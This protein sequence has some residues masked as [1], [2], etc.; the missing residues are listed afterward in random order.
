M[1]NIEVKVVIGAGYGDEGKGLMTDY[2]CEEALRKHGVSVETE[3]AQRER[4]AVLNVRFNGGAQAGH[5]VSRINNGYEYKHWVFAQYGSGTFTGVDTYLAKHFMVNPEL[6]IKEK[7]ALYKLFRTPS[8][9]LIDKKCSVTLPV[10]IMINRIVEKLRGNNRHGSC[11]LGIYETWYRNSMDSTRLSLGDIFNNY[12]RVLKSSEATAKVCELVFE[13]SY[14]YIK[15]RKQELACEL[16]VTKETIDEEFKIFGDKTNISEEFKND[17]EEAVDNI[18]KILHDINIILVDENSYK[19]MLDEYDTMVFEGA[20]GLELSMR[21]VENTPHLTPSDTGISNV[22]DVLRD[23]SD[24]AAV[25][26][27]VE[28]VYVT[29]SYKTKHGNG[30]FP[31]ENNEIKDAYSLYDSTNCKNM[32]Q[33]TLKY[34]VVDVERMKKLIKREESILKKATL[35][36]KSSVAITHLDQTLG[37]IITT[38][39]NTDYHVFTAEDLELNGTTYVSF[40]DKASAVRVI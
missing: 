22:I 26:F 23:F 13:K 39:G 40:G 33:G 15:L 11:G 19:R 24:K 27:E 30:K 5:T 18:V 21:T 38:D 2:F 6:L 3:R 14:K 16:N 8:V 28:T 4:K 25:N 7:R 32:Y 36:H 35:G 1:K 10:D 12:D 9:I 31:E 17:V 29:R 37:N 20:Q 34:G